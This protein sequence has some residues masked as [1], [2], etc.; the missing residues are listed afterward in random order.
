[1][2]ERGRRA[3]TGERKID[4]G[5]ERDMARIGIIIMLTVWIG[6][7]GLDEDGEERKCKFLKMAAA[8]DAD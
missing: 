6:Q 7:R 2:V 3:E 8:C 4:R 5:I 1:M